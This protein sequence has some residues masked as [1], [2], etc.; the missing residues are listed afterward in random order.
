MLILIRVIFALPC[1][2]LILGLHR[3]ADFLRRPVPQTLFLFLGKPSRLASPYLSQRILYLS[4]LLQADPKHLML[5]RCLLGVALL[6]LLAGTFRH[7]VYE[8][9]HAL[10]HYFT[11]GHAHHSHHAD[12]GGSDHHH[13]VLD[14]SSSAFEVHDDAPSSSEE[15]RLKLS[16]DR[17]LHIFIPITPETKSVSWENKKIV[18]FDLQL[19]ATPFR[20]TATPPPDFI[21]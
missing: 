19:P 1:P 6:V 7:G 4:N 13:V 9:T 8:V 11:D 14:I 17:I 21:A 3:K 16:Y 15:D 12:G 18:L 10:S 5:K 20:Q 2:P